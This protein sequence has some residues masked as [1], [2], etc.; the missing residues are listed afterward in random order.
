VK[1]TWGGS[2]S[3][4][5]EGY[6]EEGSGDGHLSIGAPLGNMKG[7]SFAGDFERRFRWVSLSLGAPLGGL[8]RGVRLL[9][10]LRIR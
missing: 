8:G 10:T 5:P 9:G 2:L 4:D 3:G 7:V 6:V 1:R